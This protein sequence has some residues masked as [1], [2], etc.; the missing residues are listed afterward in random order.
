MDTNYNITD[1]LL[2][3]EDQG[4]WNYISGLLNPKNGK[5]FVSGRRKSTMY[6]IDESSLTFKVKKESNE[7]KDIEY[8]S[9]ALHDLGWDEYFLE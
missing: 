4:D 3:Y 1:K 8:S 2:V 5:I 6:I 9:H 7:I